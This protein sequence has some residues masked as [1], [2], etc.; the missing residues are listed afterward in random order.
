[1]PQGIQWI[2]LFEKCAA[3]FSKNNGGKKATL[4]IDNINLLTKPGRNVLLEDLQNEAK[5]AADSGK[6][7][8]V[9]VSSEGSGTEFLKS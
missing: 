6:Y 4:V 5:A 3:D 2:P 7:R 9:F 8:V 1:M